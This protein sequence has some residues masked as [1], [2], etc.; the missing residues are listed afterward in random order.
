MEHAMSPVL[1]ERMMAAIGDAKTCP[2][3]HPIVL[4]DRDPRARCWPTA[5][6][7]PRCVILRFENEAEELLHYLRDAGFEPG[8][9]AEVKASDEEEVVVTSDAGD[10]V[11]LPQRRRD[12][13]GDRRPGAAAARGAARAARPLARQVR[14]LRRRAGRARP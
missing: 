12:R 10:H 13:V 11:G 8:M 2:H 9:K 7:A 5:R 14:P 4:G 1:E 3:G 6:S